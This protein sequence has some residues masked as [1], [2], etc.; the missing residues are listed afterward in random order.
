MEQLII[1]D[2]LAGFVAWLIDEHNFTA[3]ELVWVLESPHKWVKEFTEYVNTQKE[4]K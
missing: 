1:D 2:R 4:K 3:P